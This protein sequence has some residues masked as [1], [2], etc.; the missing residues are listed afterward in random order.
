M[1]HPP[2][3]ARQICNRAVN[4]EDLERSEG[5]GGYLSTLCL[6]A[7]LAQPRQQLRHRAVPINQGHKLRHQMATGH[8]FRIPSRDEDV[9]PDKLASGNDWLALDLNASGE[10]W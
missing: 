5:A 8:A 6:I 3:Q 1:P 7:T 4:I 9:T 10:T 2:L